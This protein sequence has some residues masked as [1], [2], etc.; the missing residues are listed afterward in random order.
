MYGKRALPVR[1]SSY[2]E[3]FLTCDRNLYIPCPSQYAS[4]AAMYSAG[5]FGENREVHGD[6]PC[7]YFSAKM[8]KMLGRR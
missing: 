6:H 3:C 7:E 8:R 5:F 2:G 4:K 1:H